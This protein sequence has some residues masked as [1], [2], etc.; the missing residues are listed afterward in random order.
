M[1]T[2]ISP[3]RTASPAVPA[4]T[5]VTKPNIDGALLV[6]PSSA[7]RFGRGDFMRPRP[8]SLTPA[9]YAGGFSRGALPMPT[10]P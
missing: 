6:R 10:V 1:D 2:A 8:V 4:T 7:A 9:V 5:L 3:V